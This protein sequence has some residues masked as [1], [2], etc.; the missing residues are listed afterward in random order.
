MPAKMLAFLCFRGPEEHR[1]EIGPPFSKCQGLAAS[2]AYPQI[3][4]LSFLPGMDDASV[5]MCFPCYQEFDSLEA[6]LAHQLTC[7]PEVAGTG[8][9]GLQDEV[10]GTRTVRWLRG[11]S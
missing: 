2:P 9:S 10:S 11:P 6:V 5:Y 3:C 7:S 4:L 1:R 8:V